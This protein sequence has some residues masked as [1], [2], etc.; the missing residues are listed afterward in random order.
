M[1]MNFIFLSLAGHLKR[2]LLIYMIFT[3]VS[4]I[5]LAISRERDRERETDRERGGGEKE[6]EFG[7][8]VVA[9]QPY[10]V[11]IFDVTEHIT[12]SPSLLSF[13]AAMSRIAGILQ[14]A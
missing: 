6:M 14:Q 11:G 10:L 12:Y 7:R 9:H 4:M 13:Q 2:V 1:L 5:I 3:R 8:T